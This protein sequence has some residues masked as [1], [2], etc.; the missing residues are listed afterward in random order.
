MKERISEKARI[1]SVTLFSFVMYV[2]CFEPIGIAEF[3]Y[4]FAIPIYLLLRGGIVEERFFKKTTLIFSILSWI[5]IIAWM[6]HVYPPSG[7]LFW[8]ALSTIVG[9]IIWLWYF[10]LPRFIAKNED[11]V[12]TRIWK[13]IVISSLWVSLE[14]L[15]GNLFTG[16]PWLLL[17]NSQWLR[18]ASIQLVEFCGTWVV[19]FTLI[20]FNIGLGEYIYRQ[21]IWHRSKFSDKIKRIGKVTPEFYIAVALILSSI[22]Y[23]N[24]NLP[25]LRNVDKRFRVGMVQTDFEGL[26]KWDAALGRT[27]LDI[28]KRLSEGLKEARVDVILWPESSTP[29]IWPV[30]GYKPMQDWIEDLVK[31]LDTPLLMG[32]E[33]Y[34]DGEN[35][36]MQGASFYVS[37][38]EGLNENYYA[39]EH[40]VP[41]GEYLPKWCFFYRQHSSSCW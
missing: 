31:D 14:W 9:F 2:L 19:S 7:Y 35:P 25:T 8:L 10:Y 3:A 34:K 15:R 23:F 32:N 21:Y 27:N 11:G 26:V 6:R 39:K 18:P 17:G 22:L 4:I 37:P 40:L 1:A 28:I 29:P 24:A 38:R 20:F 36:L 5:V 13:A 41:F 16:F 12:I 33:V 30:I